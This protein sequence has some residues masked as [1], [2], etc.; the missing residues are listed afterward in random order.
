MMSQLVSR[1]AALWICQLSRV[2]AFWNSVE[3]D[4]I[5]LR[6]VNK[7]FECLRAD[8]TIIVM[9][10]RLMVASKTDDNVLADFE[11]FVCIAVV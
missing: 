9:R 1:M 10:K 3:S 8:F 6:R 7:C 4:S 11:F 2:A 5:T